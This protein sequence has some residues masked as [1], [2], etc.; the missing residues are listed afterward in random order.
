MGWKDE[1]RPASF[2]GVDFFIDISN[3]STGRRAVLHEFPNREDPYT[4]DM[5][6]ISEGFEIEG[7]ILGDDYFAAKRL[8]QEVF[9]RQGPGELV[10]P[11]YGSKFVQVGAVNITESNRE[12]AIATF[13]AKFFEA[14]DNRFPKGVNDKGAVLDEAVGVALEDAKADFDENF[15]I[16]DLPGFAIDSA[17][18][19]IASAQE[20]FD[21]TT[22][23]FA[24][25]SDAVADL[26]FATRNLVAETNDLLQ[27]PSQL[28]ARLLDSFDLM[29]GAFSKAKD[30]TNAYATFFAFGSTEPEIVGTTPIREKERK[31]IELFNN[32]MIIASVVKSSSTAII[33]EYASF[34]DA[35]TQRI[36]ITDVLEEQIKLAE[37]TESYQSLV[38]IK[39][40][41]VDALPDVDSDLPNIKEITLYDVTPSLV[42]TYDLFEDPRNEQDIIDRNGIRHPGFIPANETLEV[43]DG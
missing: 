13:S 38:D 41:I 6:R 8:L 23:T 12:G 3:F 40:A 19:A 24:D 9:T 36:K 7:H 10:H 16:E 5:G 28:S 27:A 42:L 30:K 18:D 22:K 15:S 37:N 4:E 2:R 34:E 31:N 32:L 17:R 11:Y 35:E 14:G 39:A 29:E 1:L 25:V 20:T 33:T 43:I 26:A 21:K